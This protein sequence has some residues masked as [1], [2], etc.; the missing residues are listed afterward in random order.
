MTNLTVQCGISY[1]NDPKCA[2]TTCFVVNKRRQGR[3]KAMVPHPQSLE[4]RRLQTMVER[5]ETTPLG[6]SPDQR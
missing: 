4:P 2:T 1:G 5:P 6:K 3:N